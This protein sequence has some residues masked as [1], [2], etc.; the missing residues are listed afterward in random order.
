[1]ALNVKQNLINLK[2]PSSDVREIERR[3]QRSEPFQVQLLEREILRSL[4]DI[5]A[6]KQ[7]KI[8]QPLRLRF[9][10]TVSS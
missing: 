1:V 5:S 3:S 10:S 9:R 7:L 8:T 4:E 2:P 6:D